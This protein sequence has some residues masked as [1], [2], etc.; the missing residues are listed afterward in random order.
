M[1]RQ[2][3]RRDPRHRRGPRHPG[4]VKGEPPLVSTG[5]AR[6]GILTRTVSTIPAERAPTEIER[7]C[8][9]ET[10]R[11]VAT[12]T[13]VVG[14]V[15]V[16][17]EIAQDALLVALERWAVSGIPENPGGWIVARWTFQ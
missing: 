2:V 10:G 11:M 4:D 13:R 9:H 7:I 8:R 3:S 17:E 15:G 6:G 14:D 12:L 5:W 16:A 1:G